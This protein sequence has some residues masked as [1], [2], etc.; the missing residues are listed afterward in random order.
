MA[1]YLLPPSPCVFSVVP[2]SHSAVVE[3]PN[4]ILYSFVTLL[5]VSGIDLICTQLKV[6]RELLLLL[7]KIKMLSIRCYKFGGSIEICLQA[8]LLCL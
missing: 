8:L 7:W 3:K 6:L 4:F 2:P 1:V 5:C